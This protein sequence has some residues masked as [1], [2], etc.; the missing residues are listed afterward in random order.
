MTTYTLGDTATHIEDTGKLHSNLPTMLLEFFSQG[1]DADAFDRLAAQVPMSG[2][3]KATASSPAKEKKRPTMSSKDELKGLD[4]FVR[5]NGDVYFTRKWGEHDDVAALRS[6]REHGFY[7]LFYGAPGCGKTALVEAAFHDQPGGMYT[8]LGSGDTEVA[9]LVGG[10]VQTPSGSF[11]W[12]DGPLVKAAENGGVLLIDE[13]GLIDTKVLSVVYGLMD[14]RQ[15]Y[16][17]TANPE[18]GTVKA[19]SGFY[20]VAATNPNAPG[21]RLSEAL[22]SRFALHVEMTTDWSLARKLGA[23]QPIVT[24]AQNLAKKLAGSEV[25]WAPQMRELLAFRDI[26]SVFGTKFAIANLLAAAPEID[27]AVV[28]DVISRIYGEACM[29]AKI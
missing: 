11:V 19:T 23:P 16:T 8:V 22:L 14:G 20:V 24:A 9:D 15:E 28:S 27:R 25:S 13:I 2:K 7:A 4:K 12:E 10:Y 6:A 17:V 18:R 3:A 5:P 1:I 29:P 21:V 26:D